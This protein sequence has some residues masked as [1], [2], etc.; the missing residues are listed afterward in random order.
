MSLQGGW[1]KKRERAFSMQFE[2]KGALKQLKNSEP[3]AVFFLV[4]P[5]QH[6]VR[7]T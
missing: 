4:L 2:F 1:E 7:E 5:E 3:L 6:N